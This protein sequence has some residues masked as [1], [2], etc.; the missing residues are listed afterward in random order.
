M[1]KVKGELCLCELSEALDE[2]EYKLSR[3]I[4]IL[5]SHGLLSS[6]RDGKWIYHSLVTDQK[7]LKTIF[8]ALE[9]FPDKGHQTLLDLK[10]F[11]KRLKLRDKGRCR[12]PSQATVDSETKVKA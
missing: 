10:R 7:F 9:E 6:V 1:Q 4:K 3:H 11:E 8:K 5:K 12:V 2:P